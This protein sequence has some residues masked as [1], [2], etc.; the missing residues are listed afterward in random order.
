MNFVPA[1]AHHF[2]LNLPAAF[3]QP[4]NGNLAH[5]CNVHQNSSLPFP[6][7]FFDVPKDGT[8][9]PIRADIALQEAH[10]C[11]VRSSVC[12]VGRLPG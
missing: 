3:L 4:E 6:N 1:V 2:C 8:L 7:G 5:P 10:V 12:N 11:D 9:R